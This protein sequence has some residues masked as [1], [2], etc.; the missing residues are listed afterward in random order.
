MR[1]GRFA[2]GKQ[3]LPHTHK[4]NTYSF[5]AFYFFW[6]KFYLGH[7]FNMIRSVFLDSNSNNGFHLITASKAHHSTRDKMGRYL[8]HSAIMSWILTTKPPAAI[9]CS[10]PPLP[11]AFFPQAY[12]SVTSQYSACGTV[13]TIHG[14]TVTVMACVL[15]TKISN[16]IKRQWFK[17]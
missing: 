10:S 4:S 15:N 2:Y 8:D 3:I 1:V 9:N 5:H 6:W 7:T 17:L 12:H 14:S 16:E 13:R 11:F